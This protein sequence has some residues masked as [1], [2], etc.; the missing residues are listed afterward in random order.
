MPVALTHVLSNLPLP[1]VPGYS[2][3]TFGEYPAETQGAEAWRAEMERRTL[4]QILSRIPSAERPDIL[5]ISSP[6]YLPIPTD[7]ASFSGIKILLI[8]DW[9]VCLRFLPD[10]CPL[11]DFCFTDW[12]GYRLLKRAGV[13]NI[14][15]QP[16]FGHD[17][18][19]FRLMGGPRDL[20]ISFCGNLNSE[21]HGERNRLLAKLAWWSR[22]K[23]PNQVNPNQKHP[24][25][26]LRQT[27]GQ[28][29]VDLLNRSRLVFN[30][31]IRAEANMRLYES[32]ACGAVPLVEESNQEVSILFQEGKHFIR[33]SPNRLEATLDLLLA[34]PARLIEVSSAAQ[35]AVAKH[36]KANQLL[37]LLETA[38][39]NLPTIPTIREEA[40]LLAGLKSTIKTR[41]LGKGYN[42]LEALQEIQSEAKHL[43]N[44]KKETEPA[45][46]LSI[47]MRDP[48]ES[49]PQLEATLALYLKGPSLPEALRAFL[50]MILAKLKGQWQTVLDEGEK[51]LRAVNALENNPVLIRELNGY[52]HPPLNLGKGLNADLNQAYRQ[53]LQ[54][55]KHAGYRALLQAHCATDMAAAYLHLGKPETSAEYLDLVPDERFASLDLFQ[56]R[57]NTFILK[58]DNLGAKRVLDAW[59]ALKP[60]NM[61]QWRQ[62]YMGYKAVGDKAGV[63]DFLRATLVLV[64]VFEN[65]EWITSI[66]NLLIQE[67]AANDSN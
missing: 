63:V 59:F 6:E 40:V 52:Y 3:K 58:Q 31:S 13:S 45:V 53:D 49:L 9:N 43:P 33:Y 39:R 24:S 12:S 11:F 47:L 10:L 42:Y 64:E 8:T 62:I 22:G 27:F 25:I 23:N 50:A 26:S 61:S 67:L 1:P 66:A 14:H 28:D 32:M 29:Y 2:I 46:L 41:I 51:C 36:T 34:D 38:S 5:I 57:L 60:L 56:A 35:I 37:T 65:Q 17:P 16:L 54:G 18:E 21:M 20:D 44:L 55:E 30:Y 19:I 48:D 7:I 15:H 4:A